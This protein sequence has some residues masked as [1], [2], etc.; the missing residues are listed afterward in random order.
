[1]KRQ[2]L[3]SYEQ[4][5]ETAL[6]NHK[7]KSKEVR[8]IVENDSQIILTA[9]AIQQAEQQGLGLVCIS[10]KATP[11][12]CKIMDVGKYLY[13][14][15]K[16]QKALDKKNRESIVDLKE[17]QFRPNTGDGDLKVKANKID[18]LLQSG[19]RV[20]LVM[21]I[22]GRENAMKDHCMERFQRFLTFINKY[23]LDSKPNWQG[24][25]VLAIL[26]KSAIM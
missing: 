13:E 4:A 14:Q 17:I 26:K 16:K 20:K 10:P 5:K 2:R 24:N 1:M 21:K 19:D 23:E 8:L 15:K 7:I 6:T 11:P 18:E 25:K 9:R 22:K 12:V 3:T